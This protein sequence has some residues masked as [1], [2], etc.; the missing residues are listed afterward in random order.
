LNW[1]QVAHYDI[2]SKKELIEKLRAGDSHAFKQIFDLYQEKLIA[3]S[4][5][6]VKDYGVG[7]DIVQE[8]FLKLWT[9]RT[10]LDPEKSL[11]SYLHTI[12]RNHALNHLKRAGYD[13]DLK[14]RIWKIIEADQQR[15]KTEEKIY[16]VEIQELVTEAVERL[17]PQRQYI[18]HLSRVK[19][20]THKE[21]GNELGIS[22]NSVKNQM[23]TALK[24]IRA[25]LNQNTDIA[26]CWGISVFLILV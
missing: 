3:Y 2:Y 1:D 8:T 20:M 23:V 7:K 9:N 11:G 6:I 5:T 10:K 17:S 4:I 25:Y 19:G 21:I 13:K 15:V 12:T 18:Y 16:G 26:L 24:E 22:K 14:K